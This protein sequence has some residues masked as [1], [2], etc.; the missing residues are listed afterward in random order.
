[1]LGFKPI[2]FTMSPENHRC[3]DSNPCN[4]RFD[5]K[6]TGAGIQTHTIYDVSRKSP[7]LGFKPIQFTMSPENHRCWD[8]NPYNLRCLQKITGAGIQT[9]TIYD[10]GPTLSQLTQA[11]ASL[12]QRKKIRNKQNARTAEARMGKKKLESTRMGTRIFIFERSLRSV[13]FQHSCVTP[14]M[15]QSVLV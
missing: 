3:W 11:S 9:H 12:I 13:Q 8:S 5:Q 6:I 7:V 10:A 4:L 1:M 14:E 15:C 2:Q